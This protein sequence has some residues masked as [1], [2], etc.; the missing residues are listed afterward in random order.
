MS[1][2]GKPAK[3]AKE[4]R[5]AIVELEAIHQKLVDTSGEELQD[6]WLKSVLI[7]ML[8]PTTKKHLGTQLNQEEVKFSRAKDII[9]DFITTTEG[10]SD[11]KSESSF[12]DRIW[13]QMF[14]QGEGEWGTQ[15][16]E[17]E[18]EKD[19]E[20]NKLTVILDA[21]KGKGKGKSIKGACWE[22]GKTGHMA[23]DCKGGK[24]GKGWP[25]AMPGK[26]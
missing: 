6:S 26:G 20:E 21:L 24:G 22:C 8:D 25:T 16:K 4:T 9:N 17:E 10:S 19:E 7:Q 18:E 15:Q 5:K 11:K 13:K 12:L 14:E 1:M 2:A 3:G 23:R